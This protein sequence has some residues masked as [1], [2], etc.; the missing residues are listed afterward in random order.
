MLR[1][2]YDV[3]NWL[4]S[5]NTGRGRIILRLHELMHVFRLSADKG[6]VPRELHLTATFIQRC[7]VT[8]L[9]V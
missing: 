3:L 7:S 1:Q 2:L 4:M 5:P 6:I 8:A 9:E